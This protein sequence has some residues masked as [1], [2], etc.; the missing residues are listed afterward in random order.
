M[1]FKHRNKLMKAIQTGANL[2]DHNCKGS[3]F[4]C[5][6]GS[7]LEHAGYNMKQLQR[8]S[9]RSESASD[10]SQDALDLLEKTYG[11]DLHTLEILQDINDLCINTN[12][13]RKALA[14]K[15]CYLEKVN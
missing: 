8:E 3:K 10:L 12:D 11:L 7:L 6:I 1:K 5:V 4:R 15:V 14:E 2:R 9:K 13:R